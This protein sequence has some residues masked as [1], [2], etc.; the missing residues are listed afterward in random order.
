MKLADADATGAAGAALA[1]QLAARSGVVIYLQG[2]L[3]AGKTTFARG[4]LRRLGVR[5]AIRSPTY[6]LM[7]PYEAGNRRVLHMDLYRLRDPLEL[8][9]LAL[10]DFPPAS[11]WWLVEWP[12]RGESRLPRPDVSVH[13][14]EDGDGRRL[15]LEST[16][17]GLEA[18]M[19]ERA[20]VKP[21]T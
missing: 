14:A 2:D 17:A 7:E 15:R 21:S 19:L 18:A 6:T 12:E 3:G 16:L 9:Q 4:L 8:E 5:G 13:L 1:D 10:D 11:T 20:A